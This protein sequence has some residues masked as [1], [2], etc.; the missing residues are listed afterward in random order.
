M[1]VHGVEL[2]GADVGGSPRVVSL[3]QVDADAVVEQPGAGEVERG[4]GGG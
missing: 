1:V 4:G 2:A 3:H